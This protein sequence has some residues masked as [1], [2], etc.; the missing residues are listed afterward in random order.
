MPSNVGRGIWIVL[1][2]VGVGA[3]PDADRYGDAAAATL[4]HVAAAC[5]GLHLPHLAGMGLGTLAEIKGVPPV[6]RPRGAY[7]KMQEAALGKDSTSGHWELA[8]VVLDPPFATFPQGFPT[9]LLREFEALAGKAPLGNVS[10]SGTEIIQALGEE[11]LRT[12]RPIVYTSVDSVLQVAAHEEVLPPQELHALC[13]EVRRLADDYQIGRVIARPFVGAAAGAFQRTS[14]RKDFSM[15]PPAPTLLDYLSDAGRMVCAIGKI[16]DL[17]CERGIGQSR[18]TRDNADGMRTLLAAYADLPP[19]GLLIA[20]LIDFDMLYGHRQDAVGFGR[21]LET[22]DA[23]LPQLQAAMQPGDLLTI[24][25]DHGCDPT[26]PGSD[27][28]RE[29]VP[30]LAWHPQMTGAVGLGI[31]SGFSDLAATL[32][33]FFGLDVALAGQSFWTEIAGEVDSGRRQSG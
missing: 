3:L 24:T 14:R 31:R 15:P 19:G 20:N 33:D 23:W 22:F 2:G 21:A 4:P 26:T 9:T 11:H 12:G 8:G 30:L 25:A 13:R 7:G 6:A 17:F 5:G 29:Y 16:S 1:D 32:A 18:P 27:H 28:T 10:A